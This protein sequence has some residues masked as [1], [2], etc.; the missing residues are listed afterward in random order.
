MLV[1]KHEVRKLH[2]RFLE[3]AKTLSD[4][5]LKQTQINVGYGGVNFFML[6][7]KIHIFLHDKLYYL[8]PLSQIIK[9]DKIRLL[10][11]RTKRG[12]IC[13]LTKILI[14]IRILE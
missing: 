5:P 1:K 14:S 3:W 7:N 10:F 11:R 8:I 4:M 13:A 6:F 12:E 9:I 2:D